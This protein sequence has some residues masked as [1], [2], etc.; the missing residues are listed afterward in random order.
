[1]LTRRELIKLGAA[2]IV[3]LALGRVG[4]AADDKQ[5]PLFSHLPRWRG[6]NLL[7]KFTLALNAPYVETDFDMIAG[8]GFDFVRLPADYRCWTEASGKYKE[9][10]LREIDQAIAAGRARHIH[11]NLCLHRAPGYCVNPPKETLDLWADDESGVEARKQFA[12]QWGM[13]AAR[14]RDIPSSALSFDLV[15]EPANISPAAYARAVQAA[16]EAIRR[17]DPQRLIIAD[18]LMYEAKRSGRNRVEFLR[19]PALVVAP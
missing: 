5:T 12:A 19:L 10:I 7:E 3:P 9:P 6:F 11:V 14:Y 4:L 15:N 8:W 13:F 16:V 1:M 2:A 17:E 18:G